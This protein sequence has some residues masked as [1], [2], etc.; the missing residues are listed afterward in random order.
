MT[1]VHESTAVKPLAR[2][3][4]RLLGS[5]LNWSWIGLLPFVLF[6]IAF[7]LYPALSIVFRTF[8]DSKTGAFSLQ[9]VIELNQGI[10]LSSYWSSLRLSLTSAITG[11]VAGFALAWAI[12]LGGLPRWIRS[13][14][15][16]FSGVA[17]NFAGIPLVFAFISAYGLTGVLLGRQGTFTKLL[18]GV[19]I[20]LYPGFTLYTFWGLVAVYLFFQIPLMVLIMVPALEGLKREWREASE[21][22]GATRWQYWRYVAFPILMPALLGTTALLFANAF[23]T[24]ATAQALVGSAGQNLV[25]TVL[26]GNQFATDTL[27]NPGLGSALALGMIVIMAVTIFI[28]SYFRRISEQWLRQS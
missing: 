22:L 10:V 4:W 9:N 11:A 19:G 16:S 28:Y 25:I 17:A 20:T 6:V 15:L 18:G 2:P 12:A 23:G 14:V 13:S 8:Q 3:R 5:W 7:Q 1:T 27:S 24:H 26:V 21:N